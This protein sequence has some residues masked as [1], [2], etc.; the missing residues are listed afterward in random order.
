MII[1]KIC[2]LQLLFFLFYTVSNCQDIESTFNNI[3]SRIQNDPLKI[4]GSIN[5]FGQYY[6][7]NAL[8]NRAIP[9][10]GRIMGALNFDF[11]GI[12]MPMSLAWSNG[13][14]VFNKKIPAY[15]F[16][17]I[18]PSYKWAKILIGNRTMDF[19]KYSFSNHSFQGVGIELTPRNWNF[20]TF[21]GRLRRAR[22][23][24]FVGFNNID[25]Y[26]R[27]MGLGM[28]TGYDSG[29]EKVLLSLFKAWDDESSIPNMD[30]NFIS[31]PSENVIISLVIKKNI[32]KQLFLEINYANSG[33]TEN[34]TIENNDPSSFFSS[35]GGLLQKNISTRS[36]KAFEASVNIKLKKALLDFTYE[37][38]DPGYRTMGALFFSNDLENLSTGLKLK[39]FKS[40]WVITSR[41]G[42]QQ[43]NL[44]GNQINDYGRF[45]GLIRT[46]LTFNKNLSITG[47]ASN[48]NTVNRR[49][50]LLNPNTPIVLTELILNNKDA[51]IGFNYVLS[52]DNSRNASVQGSINYTVGNSI[53]NDL[54]NFENQTKS[55]NTFLYYSLQL[56]PYK[57]SFG[58]NTSYQKNTFS[59]NETAYTIFGINI[60]KQLLDEKLSLGLSMN[61][62]L[63]KQENDK[64]QI[65]QGKLYN[66]T[67]TIVWKTSKT[68]M[69]TLNSGFIINEVDNA[70]SFN[71]EFSEFRNTL[72]FQ[73]R[74]I[75]NL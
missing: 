69:L 59:S 48:F 42:I 75:P 13:G 8:I 53:E 46:N 61:F 4:N 51:N 20:S 17:G 45:I 39:F 37:R 62:A 73:H 35:Y 3:N 24:D 74:F 6:H 71:N 72:N 44:D 58:A 43:N 16:V 66:L 18:S 65:A 31:S 52:N 40:K 12:K 9:F 26:F 47:G 36:N 29:K 33:F 15:N 27:R 1:R 7:S 11:L 25:P 5:I 28:S 38:I 30:S 70:N 68:S 50:S 22:I 32:N 2:C 10:S 57:L 63:T 19:G 67:A 21:Y 34:R 64:V 55:T 54:V 60:N 23:E 41:M 56:K 14:V 49:S